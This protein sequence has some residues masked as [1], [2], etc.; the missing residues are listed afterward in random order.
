MIQPG[1]DVLCLVDDAYRLDAS[2]RH[3]H[4]Q[5]TSA[6]YE[7]AQV[8]VTSTIVALRRAVVTLTSLVVVAT[9]IDPWPPTALSGLRVLATGSLVGL[10]AHAGIRLAAGHGL[11]RRR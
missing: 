4:S 6:W 3:L 1:G 9:G 2:L 8:A 10:V 7:G 5:R 11:R